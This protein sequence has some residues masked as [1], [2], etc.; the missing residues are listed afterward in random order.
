M[1][2]D[3][4]TNSRYTFSSSLTIVHHSHFPCEFP[5]NIPIWVFIYDNK[6]V[7][8]LFHHQQ[9]LKNSFF[10]HFSLHST[11]HTYTFFFFYLTNCQ[12]LMAANISNWKTTATAKRAQ[13]VEKLDFLPMASQWLNCLFNLGNFFTVP[14]CKICIPIN[15]QNFIHSRVSRT[16]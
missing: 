14:V 9:T 12:A 10:H 13:K 7:Y 1:G 4:K 16:E 11:S 2:F 15:I 8:A 6:R 3:W 5:S